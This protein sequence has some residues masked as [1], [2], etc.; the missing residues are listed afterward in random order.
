MMMSDA[1]NANGKK[2]WVQLEWEQVDGIIVDELEGHILMT[3]HDI[4]A[5]DYGAHVHPDDDSYNRKLLP[6]L[7]VVYEHWAGEEATA[8]LKKQ[9]GYEN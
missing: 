9:V 6:A 8:D 2:V 5:A 4:V 3:A 7:F 1:T